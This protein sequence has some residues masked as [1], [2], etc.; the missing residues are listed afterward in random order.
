MPDDVLPKVGGGQV[1][2]VQTSAPG[3]PPSLRRGVA[4]GED[5]LD[6]G[7]GDEGVV[8]RG[9]FFTADASSYLSPSF[10]SGAFRATLPSRP[11]SVCVARPGP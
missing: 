3:H 4:E 6:V 1:G 2:G 7:V 9:R 11:R 8:L 5:G 10:L